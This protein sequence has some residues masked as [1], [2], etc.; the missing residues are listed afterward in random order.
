MF[1]HV[2]HPNL[3]FGDDSLEVVDETTDTAA[4]KWGD[5]FEANFLM[6]QDELNRE[7]EGKWNV[8]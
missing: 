1:L 2:T 5:Y 7:L 4:P 6:L 8:G 3:N